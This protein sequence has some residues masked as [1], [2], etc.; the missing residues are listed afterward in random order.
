MIKGISLFLA[1][2]FFWSVPLSA[3]VLHIGA[4]DE[5]DD[6]NEAWEAWIENEA[7]RKE[8]NRQILD[9]VMIIQKTLVTLKTIIHLSMNNKKYLAKFTRFYDLK[10]TW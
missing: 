6:G 4:E 3:A 8:R 1:L 9:I 7:K 10:V 5:V 2:L